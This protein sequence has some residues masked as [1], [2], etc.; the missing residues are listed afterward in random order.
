MIEAPVNVPISQGANALSKIWRT[1]FADLYQ[2]SKTATFQQQGTAPADP[3]KG[4]AVMW[5]SSDGDLK[6]KITAISGTTK[7]ATII[8]FSTL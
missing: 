6:I 5:M 8:D 4:S 1:W 2:G 3:A 7:T